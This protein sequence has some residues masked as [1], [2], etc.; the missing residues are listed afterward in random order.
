[1]IKNIAII[2]CGAIG[3]QIAIHLD[4]EK[5]PGSK[6]TALYDS[7][8]HRLGILHDQLKNRSVGLFSNFDAFSTSQE[9]K[10]SHLIIESASINAAKAYMHSVLNSGKDMMIMSIGVFS[11][12][13]FLESTKELINKKGNRVYLPTGAIG[14]SDII[15]SVREYITDITLITT[16][17]QKSLKGATFFQKN[18][19]DIDAIDKRTIIFEGNALEAIKEFPSNVNVSALISMSGI[20]FK[21]T[22]VIIYVDPYAQRNQHE[23]NVKWKFGEFTIIVENDPSPDNPKTSFLA[24]LSAIECL[25]SNS[26]KGLRIGS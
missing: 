10:N 4:M 17:P 3:S 1:M 12:L 11:D 22:R 14:G 21:E 25:K 2:G 18:K 7:D 20:G 6:L 8:E 16:K 15:R 23:I 24:I 9:F 19:I 13:A 5:V 26:N